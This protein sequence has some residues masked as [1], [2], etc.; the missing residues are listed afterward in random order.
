MGKGP[1]DGGAVAAGQG[2]EDT[3]ETPL[4]THFLLLLPESPTM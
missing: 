4:P 3:G 2:I 1:G